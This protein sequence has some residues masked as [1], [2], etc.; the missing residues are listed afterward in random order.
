MNKIFTVKEVC[1][2]YQISRAK[3]YL[4]WKMGCGPRRF[5]I[6]RS[7]RIRSEDAD[8]WFSNCGSRDEG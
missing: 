7:V 6:G 5:K 1:A 4:T 8:Q 3:L 2:H